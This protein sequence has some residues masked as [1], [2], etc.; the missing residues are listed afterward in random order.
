M[1]K[2]ADLDLVYYRTGI[3]IR[4]TQ[5]IANYYAQIRHATVDENGNLKLR[6]HCY[7]GPLAIFIIILYYIIYIYNLTF[8]SA[9]CTLPYTQ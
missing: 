4:H 5:E 3:I 1:R 2:A 6:I 8:S 9:K 7:T